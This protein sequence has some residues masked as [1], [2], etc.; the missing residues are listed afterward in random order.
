MYCVFA[1]II[2]LYCCKFCWTRNAVS[3]R[4]QWWF[5]ELL[6]STSLYWVVSVL[7]CGLISI[8]HHV[9]WMLLPA[10]LA[11]SSSCGIEQQ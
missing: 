10:R 7:L 8:L 4:V 1:E 9:R 11:Y 2:F 3:N 5:Y 6:S